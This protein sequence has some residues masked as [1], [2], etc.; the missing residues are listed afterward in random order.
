MDGHGRV[1]TTGQ[2]SL[3][4]EQKLK[5]RGISSSKYTMTLV[6]AKQFS[7]NRAANIHGSPDRVNNTFTTFLTMD[8][9]AITA[10]MISAAHTNKIYAQNNSDENATAI[11]PT[12]RAA[13]IG[14]GPTSGT[15]Q[16]IILKRCGFVVENIVD[17]LHKFQLYCPPTIFFMDGTHIANASHA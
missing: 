6:W 4:V 10:T 5:R 2:S 16:H 11:S 17:F 15:Y 1:P 9:L 7:R 12:F 3:L 13:E 14:K 8:S